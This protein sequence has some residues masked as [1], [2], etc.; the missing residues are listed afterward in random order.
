MSSTKN[1]D[2]TLGKISNLLR[3]G[4]HGFPINQSKILL[5]VIASSS[6]RGKIGFSGRRILCLG[7][8]MILL[9]IKWMRDRLHCI[10]IN[11]LLR[12]SIW[13]FPRITQALKV[14]AEHKR[15]EKQLH[16][17][18]IKNRRERT[19]REFPW[20]RRMPRPDI[21]QWLIRHW[22]AYI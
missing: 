4:I 11:H 19:G 13:S 21:F 2:H 14:T 1:I 8:T 6:W 12:Y 9:K 10:W 16:A 7:S 5:I 17:I 22:L 20:A 18:V 15:G 3:P